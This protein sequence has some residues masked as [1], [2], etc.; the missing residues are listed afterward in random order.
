M[1]LTLIDAFSFL[2]G[3]SLSYLKLDATLSTGIN[4]ELLCR[5]FFLVVLSGA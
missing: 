2:S 5:I 4:T 1:H 3:T